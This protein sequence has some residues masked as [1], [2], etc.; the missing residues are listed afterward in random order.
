[1]QKSANTEW[2]WQMLFKLDPEDVARRRLG[3]V[4]ENLL[5]PP[6][7]NQALWDAQESQDPR[8]TNQNHAAALRIVKT[9]KNK[10][11]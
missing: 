6:V 11:R 10:R 4:V 2:G 5:G 7:E 8:R 3:A 9:I 1:M